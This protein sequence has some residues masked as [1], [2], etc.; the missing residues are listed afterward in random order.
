MLPRKHIVRVHA[1]RLFFLF[2]FCILALRLYFIQIHN[3]TFYS[4]FA[5]QQYQI[6][7]KELPPRAPI[8]DRNNKPLALN[9]LRYAAFITP[10]NVHDKAQLTKILKK[11]FPSAHERYKT[12]PHAA[13]MYV[14]RKLTESQLELLE[15]LN[16]PDI[17]LMQEPQRFYTY[18]SLAPVIGLTDID[19]N[20]QS[21]LEL[22]YDKQ[23]KGTPTLY[24]LE[25]DARRKNYYFKKV[26]DTQGQSGKT[27]QT[28]LDADLQEL[29]YQE[30]K[31]SVKQWGSTDGAALIMNPTNGDILACANY[32]TLQD[33][34]L[35]EFN[36]ELIKN[37]ALTDAH[38][39]GSV[40]KIFPALA[41]LEE[42]V[43]QADELIDCENIKT[44]AIDG[45]TFST[46][47]AHGLLS[48]VD[49]VAQSNNFGTSKVAKRLGK[50]LY[51]HLKRIGF[52]TKTGIKFPLE[53]AGYINPPSKWTTHSPF[54]LS[55]G[56][57]ISVTLLQLMQAFGMI[58]EQGI[59]VKPRLTFEEPI[60]RSERALYSKKTLA[61]IDEILRKTITEGT[62][63]R[64]AI[65]NY[66]VRGKTGT[67]NLLVNGAYDKERNI[68]SFVAIV[69]KGD[70]TRVIGTFLKEANKKNVYSSSVV[71]PLFERIAQKMLLH[72]QI[73]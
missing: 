33:F 8:V 64:A 48:Y 30:L 37:R 24:Y 70:Y 67:A 52:G 65:K 51:E 56:Y 40:M 27:L 50:K 36:P 35:E 61:S 5:R 11:H 4:N 59:L 58:A 60:K 54:S 14:K 1:L 46:W 21:G 49:V 41:A 31:S 69:H 3:H 22:E 20:G 7:I 25:K 57:E 26:V 16:T 73:F 2:L 19:N 44:G 62:A 66:S 28:T 6:T 71:V 45:I 39:F 68:F 34:V 42:E 53:G 15:K 18:A 47:K 12:R 23:L 43:V 13:F 55:F 38:E 32:P 10:N 17:Y 29:V 63:H 9:M 72:D